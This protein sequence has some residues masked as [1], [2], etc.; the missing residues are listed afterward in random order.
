MRFNELHLHYIIVFELGRM[1]I[2]ARLH[3]ITA[4]NGFRNVKTKGT[5]SVVFIG[6]ST[7]AGPEWPCR[8][9]EGGF[10]PNKVRA[11]LGGQ[12]LRG[13]GS[14]RRVAGVQCL[15]L[16]WPKSGNCRR[17]STRKT[18]AVS[19]WYCWRQKLV[20]P[21]P[22]SGQ[23]LA[24]RILYTLLAGKLQHQIGQARFCTQ[25]CSFV[26]SAQRAPLQRAPV[27]K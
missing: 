23:A 8:W 21:C 13:G 19:T 20:I 12:T 24:S 16:P 27:E 25:S 2:T 14:E 7:G 26:G 3:D 11:F 22:T 4:L 17:T 6:I 9:A 15:S 5:F 1:R 10:P 18:P